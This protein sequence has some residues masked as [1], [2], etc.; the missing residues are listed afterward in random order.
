MPYKDPEKIKACNRELVRKRRAFIAS[1]KNQPC[2][3]CGVQYPPYV[4]QFDHK[5]GHKKVANIAKMMS[6]QLE[7]VLSE[8]AKC[9]IVC[10][11]CHAMRTYLRSHEK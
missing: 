3:D 8:I 5:P 10:A 2:T 1:L 7:R 4:M 9:D 11:N 6:Y